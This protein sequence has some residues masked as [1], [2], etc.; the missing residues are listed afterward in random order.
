MKGIKKVL[1]AIGRFVLRYYLLFILAFGAYRAATIHARFWNG[2]IWSDTEG[3]YLYLPGIFINGGFGNLFV[4]TEGQ[5]PMFP[6]T[7]KRYTKYTYGI[8]LMEAPFFLAA[9]TVAKLS[10]QP[11]DGYSAPYIRAVQLAALLY[12]FL[13]LLV[14]K[15]ILLRHFS[16]GITFMAIVGLYFGTNLMHYHIQEP[17]MS[18]IYSFFLFTLFIYFTP[19]FYERPGW[20]I[21]A[22]MGLLLGLIT[23]IRPT[24]ALLILYLVF[25]NVSSR[26]ALKERWHFFLQHYK[27]LLIIP[28]LILLAWFPQFAYWK[29]ISG[30]WLIYSYGDEGFIYWDSPKFYKVL[31]YIQNGWLLFSPMAGLT[32]IG[33][34]LGAWKNHYNIAI[35]SIILLL[36][37][38]LFASWWC[39]WFGGALGQRSYVELYTLLAFPY[40]YLI[41]LIFRQRWLIPKVLFVLLWLALIHYSYF[42]TVYFTGPHYEWWEWEL[43]TNW[44]LHFDYWQKL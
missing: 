36:S 19:R 15:R 27:E 10:G 13:G 26:T 12:G 38:Y 31:F 18:H 4:R 35:I 20:G 28:V 3:Y 11:A 32:I 17:G 8:A 14:L 23:L 9:H 37:T 21:F 24:N 40:A 25:Y 29:Y 33:C 7:N 44:A 30:N 5:F 34:L 42:L 41:Q 6:G 1:S 43:V 22:G 39:W 2:M 16:A